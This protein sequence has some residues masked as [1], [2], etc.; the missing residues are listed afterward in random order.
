MANQ[1]LPRKRYLRTRATAQPKTQSQQTSTKSTPGS[2]IKSKILPWFAPWFQPHRCYDPEESFIP[3]PKVTFLIDKPIRLECQI[4]H[5]AN[6]Q[7]RSDSEPLD[8]SDFS[9]MPCG[10]AACS[11]CL[12][13]WFKTQ[14]TCPFCRTK[15]AYPGC[16]HAIPARSLTKEGLHLLPRTLPD[17]G[18]I[19]SF[20]A[21][22]L[23]VTLMT[24]AEEKF[25]QVAQ[26]FRAAR[27]RFSQTQATA[28]ELIMFSKR[29]EFET[30]F[31]DEV[32][33]KQLNTWLTSW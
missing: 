27:Q 12:E 4:C 21:Q 11:G 17:Q 19:P 20:C 32:Y 8:E 26:E 5:Q 9:L 16:G 10:H 6:C 3:F 30:L 31:R 25:Q 7:I 23:K 15:L 2:W 29:D 1:T 33:L 13:K 24:Q 14:D 18:W 28:D 22:C